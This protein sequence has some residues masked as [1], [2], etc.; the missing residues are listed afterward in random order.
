M[1]NNKKV[2]ESIIKFKKVASDENNDKND[3][4]ANDG[5]TAYVYLRD[6][7]ISYNKPEWMKSQWSEERPT[8][9]RKIPAS[10]YRLKRNNTIA[11]NMITNNVSSPMKLQQS[12]ERKKQLSFAG[13]WTLGYPGINK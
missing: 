6:G 9:K 13:L 5:N 10:E 4:I 2:E 3:S 1:F 8:I 7:Q 11:N 12:E